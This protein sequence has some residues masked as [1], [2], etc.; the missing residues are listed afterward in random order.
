MAHWACLGVVL[1]VTVL[2]G[3]G[4]PPPDPSAS[5][6]T[7]GSAVAGPA[8]DQPARTGP[9]QTASLGS[10]D[11]RAQKPGASSPDNP[12]ATAPGTDA[13]AKTTASPADTQELD[14][15]TYEERAQAA[16]WLRWAE[17]APLYGEALGGQTVT[18]GDELARAGADEDD[19][20]AQKLPEE[21]SDETAGSVPEEGAAG[22]AL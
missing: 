16:E 2:V 21:A 13:R 6:D 9:M 15:Q 12:R 19:P 18:D 11:Q 22:E 4:S 8:V 20:E 14:R 17:T 3:C 7:V 10:T 1:G 5:S